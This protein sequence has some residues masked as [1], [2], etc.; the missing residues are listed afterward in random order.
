MNAMELSDYAENILQEKLQTIPGVSSVGLYGQKRPAMR[1]WLNPDKMAAYDVTAED[2][3][4]ALD[5][6]NVELPGGK[7]RGNNTELIVKTFGRLTTEDDFNNII[8]RQ[9]N[10][11]IIRFSDIG[12]ALLGPENEETGVK[13]NGADGISLALIPLPGAN[14]IEVANEFYK[15]FDQIQKDLPKGLDLAVGY[16][17]SK[18]VRQSVTDV[19]ETLAIAI[20][21]VVLIVFLFF[22]GSI[23]CAPY[24]R[25]PSKPSWKKTGL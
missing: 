21:L 17:K 2:V 13:L 24:A 16:D 5:K 10:D 23:S 22:I 1:L 25:P 11:Q 9:T 15:R 6:E 8:I 20:S 12:E 19:L 18:F 14:D 4:I 7:V 3:S